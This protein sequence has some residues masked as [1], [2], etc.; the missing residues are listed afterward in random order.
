MRKRFSKVIFLILPIIAI[1]FLQGCSEKK[2]PTN[3]ATQSEANSS[4]GK[5]ADILWEFKTGAA[6]ASSPVKYDDDIIF[7][8][9]D[10]NLYSVDLQT[11]EKNWSFDAGVGINNTPIIDGD[12]VIFSTNSTC[13]ELDAKT[14]KEIWR[15]TSSKVGKETLNGYD[16]HLPSP[17]LYKDLVIFPNRSGDIYGLNKSTGKLEWEYKAEGSSDILTTPSIQGDIMCIGDVKGNAIAV[18]LNTQ[19]TIWSNN[20]GSN[21]I[22]AAFVYKDYAYFAGRGTTLDVFN[23]KD[24]SKAWLY[25]DPSRSWLTGDMVAKDDIV[26]VPGSDNRNVI[27]F[28]YDTGEKVKS[29]LGEGN[30]FSKPYIDNN[31]MYF[32]AGDVYYSKSG[33]ISGY[34]LS[35][36]KKVV[37][38]M[39]ESPMYSSPIVIDNVLYVG[40]SNGKLYAIDVKTE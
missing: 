1:S 25:T 30:I 17:V 28:K 39:I 20:T 15:Y 40:S 8:S 38:I 22:H 16:Y 32:S 36:N 13:Y 26:Y 18:D 35:T 2:E 9:G 21:I 24:G 31:I 19:K 3:D 37:K 14:G 4:E 33:G 7:G 11:H 29:L 27:G 6:I 23:I 5:V 34:D 10:K 12:N